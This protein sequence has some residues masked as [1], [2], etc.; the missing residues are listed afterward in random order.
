MN[1]DLAFTVL[2]AAVMPWWAV[3]LVAPRS[4]LAA[5]LAAH[6]AVFV[7]LAIV[8]A[9]LLASA[10]AGGGASGF[11]FQG[12]RQALTT[13]LGF[14]AGWTHYLAFDLFTGAWILRESRRLD[15]EPRPYLF[16]TLMTGPIGLGAYLVRRAARLRG[17]G[18]IGQTDLA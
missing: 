3:W 14:L 9:G 11:D 6:G 10:A 7:V 1:A 18:G 5:R 15:L 4:A 17:L 8:Y 2:N 16:F 12:V 13:D